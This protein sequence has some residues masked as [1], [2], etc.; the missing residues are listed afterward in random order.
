MIAVVFDLDG[1]LIESVAETKIYSKDG[2]L[3]RSYK[4]DSD[5]VVNTG[6]VISFEDFNDF[7][8]LLKAKKLKLF[9]QMEL[10]T[11]DDE[12]AVY[13]L[14]ARS[15][16]RLIADWLD[17]EG[18]DN[19]DVIAMNEPPFDSAYTYESIANRKRLVLE[20]LI[21]MYDKVIFYDNDPANINAVKDLKL[22][23][24]KV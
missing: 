7:E 20:T 1:T 23:A 11:T 3:L 8:I 19:V 22:K 15:S 21:D 10:L 24:I 12:Y 6:E 5:V 4:N 9:K 18:V 13:I 14:T 16:S 2:K 17:I